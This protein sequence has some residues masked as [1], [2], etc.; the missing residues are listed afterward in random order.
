MDM[1]LRPERDHKIWTEFEVTELMRMRDDELLTF[2]EIGNVLG[3][4][5]AQCEKRYWFSKRRRVPLSESPWTEQRI[6]RLREL[7]AE[8]WSFSE[9]AADLG[10]GLT[11]NACIGK[12]ARIGLPGR[13]RNAPKRGTTKRRQA[14]PKLRIVRRLQRTN[15]FNN[16]MKV[17]ETVEGDEPISTLDPNDIPVEQRKTLLEL[18]PNDCRWPYGDPGKDNFF[19]CGAPKVDGF[20]YCGTHRRVSRSRARASVPTELAFLRHRMA[21]RGKRRHAA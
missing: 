7:H 1:S 14:P 12:A 2:Q 20:S 16:D 10:E 8:G 17:V 21:Q 6:A 5:P 11:R 15:P 4:R 9:I 13:E 18:E 19:F 3:C